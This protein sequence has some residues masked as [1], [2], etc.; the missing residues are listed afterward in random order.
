[1]RRLRRT[2]ATVEDGVILVDSHFR[3]SYRESSGTETAVHEYEVLVRAGAADGVV[4]TVEV[5]PRVLPGPE[6]PGAVASAQAIVGRPLEQIRTFVR[7][8]MRDDSVC[9]HLN[10]QL[11]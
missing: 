3:D 8:E 7:T 6:C 5:R 4:R 9:T 11:R 10:D 1:M 2:D